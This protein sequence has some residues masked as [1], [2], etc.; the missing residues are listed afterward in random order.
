M[1]GLNKVLSCTRFPPQPDSPART[2]SQP[3]RRRSEATS[4]PTHP[5]QA[6][7]QPLNMASNNALN[8][9][10]KYTSEERAEIKE[11]FTEVS[12]VSRCHRNACGGGR[13]GGA[14]VC[15]WPCL[16]EPS[17]A[18]RQMLLGELMRFCSEYET[19]F[20][21]ISFCC[22]IVI[23]TLFRMEPSASRLIE[24]SWST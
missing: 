18:R 4:N 9:T 15:T 14:D 8:S 23:N 12:R 6:H 13:E 17:A 22:T 21:L 10:K 19:K 2:E 5:L 1:V 20:H 3:R 7:T 24:Y 11:K 16:L